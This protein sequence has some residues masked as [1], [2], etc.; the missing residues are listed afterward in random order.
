ME[1]GDS[2]HGIQYDSQ[3][4][5]QHGDSETEVSPSGSHVWTYFTKDQNYKENKKASC[6]LCSKIYTCSGGSTSNLSNHLRKKHNKLSQKN[7]RQELDIREA[8]LK[9]SAKKVI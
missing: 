3:H 7:P 9:G 8:F 2:Q 6:N 1:H 4:S 5:S